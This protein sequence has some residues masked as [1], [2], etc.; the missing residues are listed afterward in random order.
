MAIL[1]AGLVIFF[2]VHLF[3]AFRSRAPEKD[4]KQH[5]GAG[6]YMALYSLVSLTGLGLIIW[7]YKHAPG[8]PALYFTPIEVRWVSAALLLIALILLISSFAPA[9]RIKRT[10]KHPMITAIGLWALAHLLYGGDLVPIALFGS[11]FLYAIIAR[12][13]FMKRPDPLFEGA[14]SSI[15]DV[16]SVA[17]GTAVF[18]VFIYGAHLWLFGIQPI[19]PF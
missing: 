4:L 6:R 5:F 11:F 19:L 2:S 16:I 13:A 8:S 1:I 15:G 14:P 9:G 18:F 12:L 7:G 3:A 17:A 10:L